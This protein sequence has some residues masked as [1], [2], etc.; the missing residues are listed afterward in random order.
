MAIPAGMMKDGLIMLAI[1]N[2]TG[3]NGKGLPNIPSHGNAWVPTVVIITAMIM[4][5]AR[6]I[7]FILPQ[8]QILIYAHPTVVLQGQTGIVGYLF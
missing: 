7:A 8:T 6:C 5:I 1:T 4:K 3:A 2:I